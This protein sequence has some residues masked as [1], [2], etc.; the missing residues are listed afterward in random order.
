MSRPLLPTELWAR[1]ESGAIGCHCTI[2]CAQAHESATDVSVLPARSQPAS[3]TL[4]APMTP[5]VLVAI[6]GAALLGACVQDAQQPYGQSQA[7]QA[8][9]AQNMDEPRALGLWKSSF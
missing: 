2:S 3:G 4:Q 7:Y 1:V 9:A 5:K 8:P 6:A